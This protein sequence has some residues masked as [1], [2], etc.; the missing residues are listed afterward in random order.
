MA[1]EKL[2]ITLAAAR[3]NA[4]LLQR[5]VSQRLGIS[6]PTLVSWEAG[7]TVPTVDKAQDLASLYG[8]HLDDLIFC[9]ET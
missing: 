7:K 5:D 4:G 2:R 9:R 8:V 1:E 3:V 6:V